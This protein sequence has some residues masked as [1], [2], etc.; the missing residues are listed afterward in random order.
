M[1]AWI[2]LHQEHVLGLSASE[3]VSGSFFIQVKIDHPMWSLDVISGPDFF[4]PPEFRSIPLSSTG[5][6][7][8][9]DYSFSSY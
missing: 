7:F 6:S 9:P 2:Y 5:T 3:G 1:D 8:R 4:F